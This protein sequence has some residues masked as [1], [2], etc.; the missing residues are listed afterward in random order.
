MDYRNDRHWRLGGTFG[1]VVG[2]ARRTLLLGYVAETTRTFDVTITTP[3]T[4]FSQQDEQGLLRYGAG[5]EQNVHERLTI[6]GTLGI[7]RADFG[8]Q[9]TNITPDR[10]LECAVGL[11]VRF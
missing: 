9:Q 10:P 11:N 8:N 1:Y 4:T 5:V 7:S 6:R 2:Q 3:S